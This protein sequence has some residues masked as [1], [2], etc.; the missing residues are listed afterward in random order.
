MTVANQ[1]NRVSAVGSGSAGQAIPFSFPIT[2]TSDL[3]VTRRVTAT[4]VPTPLV[5]TTDYTVVITG[6]TGGTLTTVTAIAVTAEA[7]LVRDTPNTQGLDLITGGTFNAENVE[8][9]LDKSVKLTIENKD[10][11]DR[12]VRAPTTD[13]TSLDMELPNSI[14]RADQF[15]AFNSDGEPVVV[16]SVAPDTA[17]ITAYMETLLDDAN[18]ATARATLGT[19]S[20]D[21]D[22]MASDDNTKWATQQSV[23]AYGDSATQTMTNKTLTAPVLTS[24]VL[25]TSLSGTAFLDEDNMVSDAAD[26][27][28]SQQSIKAHVAGFSPLLVDGTAGR[29]QRFA[30]LTVDD[31]SNASTL[32][33][34]LANQFNGDVIAETDNVAK[35]ATTGSF[36][37]SA[38]GQSLQIEAAGLSGNVLAALGVMKSNASGD[39]T[40]TA[41]IDPVSNDIDVSVRTGGT[42]ADMTVLVDTGRMLFN[43]FY[44]TDA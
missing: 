11:I 9:A 38:T 17:T 13:A 16:A 37:L 12:S 3:V 25:N 34:T 32:K 42:G 43:I 19:E 39:N 30:T 18:A 33:C 20:L 15:L 4:G 44:L 5:E 36:T 35:N 8:D 27:A 7:H 41:D 28:A 6:D 1:S 2:T 40:L 31:G 14:D 22:D 29:V 10:A 23:K 26:K 21:E 24:P